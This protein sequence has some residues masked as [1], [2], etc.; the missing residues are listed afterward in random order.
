MAARGT[1]VKC[2]RRGRRW[3]RT[4]VSLT[5]K[6]VLGFL[7]A[8]VL[9][10][11]QML[12][13]SYFTAQMQ[14]AS[15]QVANALAASVAVQSGIDAT[16][17]IHERVE[18]D[19]ARATAPLGVAV[20]RVYVDELVA[21]I[22]QIT[23][24]LGPGA[25]PALAPLQERL[26]QVLCSLTD[27]ERAARSDDADTRADA[28]SFFDDAVQDVGE[29]LLQTQIHVRGLADQGVQREREVH[30][31]P[32]RASLAITLIGV[33]LMGLFVAW[34][35]R[36]LVT[37][38]ER[39]QAELER[40]VQQR[41][42]ELGST[43]TALQAEIVE[44]A[45]AEARTRDLHEQL[46]ATSRRAG[47]AELANGVLHNVGNVLNSVNVSANVLIERFATS[48]ADGLQK[49]VALLEQHADDLPAFVAGPQG[50]KLQHYL[51]T[52][53]TH[54]VQERAALVAETRDLSRQVDHM[55]EIV[56]RQQ[57]YARVAGTTAPTRPSQVVDDVLAMHA[58]ALNRLDIRVVRRV[59]F[60]EECELDRSRVLQI[61]MNLISNA[62]H[63][64]RD[65]G[66]G[67][68]LLEIAIERA[69]A[70]RFRM[71]VRDNG[72]GIAADDL[73]RV[74]AHG[75]TTKRDG[76]GF[77]LHHSA[78]AATEM[79]GRLWAESAGPGRGATFVLELP[80]VD[81]TAAVPA[82]TG[83]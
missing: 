34:F 72:V 2:A 71:V 22:E 75:F 67:G 79:G 59:E 32:M 1:G 60:D 53:A 36:Q 41:T 39:A 30:G 21:R 70:G 56:S 62:K 80:L 47:M 26:G 11:G 74:F 14:E 19:L 46:V 37:P 33:V 28:L 7:F 23:A 18:T 49:A 77:G 76:H 81:Q 52:L 42:A 12:I 8:L 50:R 51:A 65:A 83:P 54:L 27:L 31:R 55:K 58:A 35:S 78:N 25:E 45:R 63:A 40:A 17:Q 66:R 57:S 43:V 48:R 4:V 13:S 38:I 68:G 15:E 64:V 16:R 61:L 82:A 6:L 10:I 5:Q 24:S 69:G 73:T 3:R 20:H 44:R 29:A 9:Q